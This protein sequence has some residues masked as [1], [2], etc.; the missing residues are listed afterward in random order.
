MK[1]HPLTEFRNLAFL[2]LV[3]IAPVFFGVIYIISEV[4]KR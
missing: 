4:L 2:I 1:P 3:V